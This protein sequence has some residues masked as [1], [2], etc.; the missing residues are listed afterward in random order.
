MIAEESSQSAE[1]DSYHRDIDPGLGAGLGGFVVAH[2]AALAHQPAEGSL[3]DPA[4]GQNHEPLDVLG[5]LDHFH[6]ELGAQPLDPLGEG[7]AAVP[8]IDPEQPQPG[9][10]AQERSEQG[11]GP[12]ALGGAGRRDPHAQHQAERVDQQVALAAF[13]LFGPI[14]AHRA[15]VAV[16]LDALAVQD[17]GCGAGTLGVRGPD[18]GPQPGV[19]RFPSVVAGPLAKDMIHGFPGREVGGQ[20]PPL[21]AAF[22]HVEDRLDDPPPVGGRSAAFLGFGE[23]GSEEGPLG[24]RQAGVINSDFHR[25][26]WA[27]LRMERADPARYVKSFTC[28]F[29]ASTPTDRR[30]IPT[31]I[32]TSSFFRQALRQRRRGLI[33]IVKQDLPIPVGVHREFEVGHDQCGLLGWDRGRIPS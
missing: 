17:G 26:D 8:A 14:V 22:A 16:G 25:L 10:P 18:V 30:R 7:R 32:Q 2:Q 13:D 33:R 4:A 23:H 20:E 6:F 12:F 21:D 1:L 15:A 5:A 28:I 27:A 9:E 29:S 24:V 31:P 3:H 11:L 19:E